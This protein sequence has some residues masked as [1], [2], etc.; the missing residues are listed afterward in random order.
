MRESNSGY[1]FWVELG[2]V[3]LLF[4][5]IGLVEVHLES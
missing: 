4:L 2:V 3:V 1:K 5:A